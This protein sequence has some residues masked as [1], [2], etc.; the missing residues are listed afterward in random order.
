MSS[1][2]F[3]YLADKMKAQRRGKAL[4]GR[5]RVFYSSLNALHLAVELAHKRF[6]RKHV[7]SECQRAL[8]SDLGQKPKSQIA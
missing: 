3:S 4:K 6:L 2:Q 1:L 5:N 8:S 7:E